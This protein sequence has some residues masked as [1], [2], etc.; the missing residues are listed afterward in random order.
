MDLITSDKKIILD[1]GLGTWQSLNSTIMCKLKDYSNEIPLV[2]HLLS[3]RNSKGL[4]QI[5]LARQLN[6]VRDRFSMLS[7]DEAIYDISDLSKEAPW[8]GKLS[9]VIT[10]C[11]NLFTTNDGKDLFSELVSLFSYC[12]YTKNYVEET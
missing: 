12:H 2:L 6:L 4:N 1:V 10:S 7:P 9:P 5:E 11:G 3:N 8:K